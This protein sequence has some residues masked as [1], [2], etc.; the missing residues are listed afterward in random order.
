MSAQLTQTALDLHLAISTMIQDHED[1]DFALP[2]LAKTHLGILKEK[3]LAMGR[4][5]R[6]DGDNL[7]R[8]VHAIN[9][10]APQAISARLAAF[11]FSTPTV[12]VPSEIMWMPGGVHTIT[13]TRAG[14][15]VEATIRVDSGTA[16]VAQRAL[17]KL[18]AASAQRPYFD[19]DHDN[20]KASAWPLEFVWR[21]GP[22]PGVYVRVE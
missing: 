20:G 3:N 1:G 22:Q 21:D 4:A 17:G 16:A 8:L 12:G 6:E 11:E 10:H 19:F 2:R 7:G 9:A 18:L 15:P 13:A 5:L 14:Q